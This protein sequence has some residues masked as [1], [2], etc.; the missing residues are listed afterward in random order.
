MESKLSDFG[1]AYR[2]SALCQSQRVSAMFARLEKNTNINYFWMRY[3]ELSF[4]NDSLSIPLKAPLLRDLIG[5]F[6][7]GLSQK[8]DQGHILKVMND[9]LLFDLY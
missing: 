1:L 7:H 6:S 3:C 8:D 5:D 2:D 9:F 4:G